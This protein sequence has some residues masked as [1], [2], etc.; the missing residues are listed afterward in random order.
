M[1]EKLFFGERLER[2]AFRINEER[3]KEGLFVDN[4]GNINKR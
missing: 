3:G 1:H 2:T 4:K